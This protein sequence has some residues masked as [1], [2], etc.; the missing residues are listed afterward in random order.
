LP[1]RVEPLGLRHL[2]DRRRIG[3]LIEHVDPLVGEGLGCL[4]LA[5]RVVPAVDPDDL[6]LHA[7]VHAP[8][9]E[10]PRVDVAKNL[11]D[12]KRRDEAERVAPGHLARDDTEQ[13]RALVESAL[14]HAEVLR[15]LVPGRVL[16]DDVGKVAR[17][18]DRGL[19]EAERRREDHLAPVGHELPDDALGVRRLGDVLD[20]YGLH[21]RAEFLS[22]HLAAEIVWWVQPTSPTGPE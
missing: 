22:D 17:D 6:G 19:H 12:R 5:G 10:R 9:A 16:E 2:H 11:G 13:I 3:V 15:G 8:R 14:I 18:L 1:E 7:R 4:F 20:E 21:A